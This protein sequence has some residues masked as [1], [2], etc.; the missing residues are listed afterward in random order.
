MLAAKK[1]LEKN[2]AKD[3]ATT[4]KN[5]INDKKAT[6]STG[7]VGAKLSSKLATKQAED[8]A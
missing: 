5:T 4:V 1:Q 8:K 7:E 2:K 6:G 3:A